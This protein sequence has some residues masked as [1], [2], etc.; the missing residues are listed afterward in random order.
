MTK[1]ASTLYLKTRALHH[2]PRLV[3]QH[4]RAVPRS[5]GG[6]ILITEYNIHILC[7]GWVGWLVES[8][9][10]CTLKPSV[11][12]RIDGSIR[13][14]RKL[15]CTSFG[16]TLET[17]PNIFPVASADAVELRLWRNTG[18]ASST[19]CNCKC[20]LW[21]YPAPPFLT[22]NPN[23]PS[24]STLW[25]YPGCNGI[26]IRPLKSC[27]KHSPNNEATKPSS[28]LSN[29]WR[30]LGR[31]SSWGPLTTRFM[32]RTSSL[33]ALRRWLLIHG[34]K[35]SVPHAYINTRMA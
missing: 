15:R 18:L 11:H 34:I 17:I 23:P 6:V 24:P 4:H 3:Q 14:L 30:G 1:F 12:V 32:A 2:I 28:Q 5:S 35:I 20:W 27:Q 21:D 16:T 25:H 22:D 9:R 19:R 29:R 8:I 26:I 10:T 33:W 13:E 7:T 31:R